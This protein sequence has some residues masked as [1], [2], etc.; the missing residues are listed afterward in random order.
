MMTFQEDPVGTSGVGAHPITLE[1]RA[2]ERPAIVRRLRP[3]DSGVP[4]SSSTT[5]TTP[6][7]Q[8]SR[9][10][11][12]ADT[13]DS[14]ISPTSVGSVMSA[15]RPLCGIVTVTSIGERWGRSPRRY[16]CATDTSASARWKP[17]LAA[18]ARW[19]S[20]LCPHPDVGSVSFNDSAES[21]TRPSPAS[22]GAEG[23]GLPASLGP[24]PAAHDSAESPLRPSPA[25]E[26]AS[27]VGCLFCNPFPELLEIAIHGDS[28]STRL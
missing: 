28:F 18:S 6:A 2:F 13:N 23:G 4:C 26:G 12:S 3:T 20:T 1:Q 22:K 5:S 25:S 17:R 15:R 10:A 9:R 24:C 21:S 11:A 14:P 16:P 7:S 19:C 8:L 27:E